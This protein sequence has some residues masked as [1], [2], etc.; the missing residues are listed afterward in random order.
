LI[1]N[2]PN[3]STGDYLLSKVGYKN[4]DFE[5]LGRF[6]YSE[7]FM[8]VMSEKPWKTLAEFV[9]HAKK[10]PDELK[11]SSTSTTTFMKFDIFSKAAGIKMI[12][13]PMK[14]ETESI[15]AMVG[16]HCDVTE[17]WVTSILSMKE[18]GKMR[19]LAAFTAVRSRFFP[20]VPTFAEKGYP[21]VNAVVAFTGYGMAV[22]KG[23]P[24]EVME[25]LKDAIAKAAKDPEVQGTVGETWNTSCLHTG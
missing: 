23:T 21:E 12:H 16:G 6:A 14:G 9:D 13:V 2:A 4:S 17:G 19:I 1:A 24:K 3:I 15:A 8:Y 18:A 22:P 20:E 5:Y 25:I 7:T 11:F 10:N